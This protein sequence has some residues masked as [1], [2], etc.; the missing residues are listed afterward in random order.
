MVGPRKIVVDT[1]LLKKSSVWGQLLKHSV[2]SE[3]QEEGEATSC[4]GP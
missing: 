2:G 1:V 3:M 4:L